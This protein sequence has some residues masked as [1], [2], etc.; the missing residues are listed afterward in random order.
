MVLP[1]KR[2]D[3]LIVKLER[4]VIVLGFVMTV[5]VVEPDDPSGTFTW[6]ELSFRLG[7][8]AVTGTTAVVKLTVPVKLPTPDRVTDPVELLPTVTV[9]GLFAA[10][11]KP[12][13]GGV[14]LAGWMASVMISQYHVVLSPKVTER[15]VTVELVCIY[16]TTE[17]S[18]PDCSGVKPG[19]ELIG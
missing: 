2:A 14:K 19:P 4:P 18:Q 7:A 16:S 9:I 11:V 6:L 15:L 10:I 3:P 1:P 17:D 8:V 5:R 13:G 12:G